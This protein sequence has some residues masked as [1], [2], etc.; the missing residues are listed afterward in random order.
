[1]QSVLLSDREVDFD[2]RLSLETAVRNINDQEILSQWD[3]F[4]KSSTQQE[5]T[6]EA[7]ELLGLLIKKSSQ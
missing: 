1:V 5:A 2:T 3:A 4:T 6:K 7:K